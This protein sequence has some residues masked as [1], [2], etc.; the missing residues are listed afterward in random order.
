VRQSFRAGSGVW[1][2]LAFSAVLSGCSKAEPGSPEAV[3]DAF[4]EA[5]FRHADQEAAKR[6]TAFGATK[7]LDSELD[8]VKALRAEG[9]GPD[10][11]SLEVAVERGERSN[12]G[13]RVRFDYVLRFR[14]GQGE[15]LRHA[16]VELTKIDDEWKV[17]R[18]GLDQAAAAPAPS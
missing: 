10:Q 12:R 2:A 18:V 7:M 17:V 6:Y 14:D 1:A 16:D 9:Y 8:A 11:A 15:A 4:V 3:A 5:Y 13:E